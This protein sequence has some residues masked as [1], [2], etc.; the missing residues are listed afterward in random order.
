M[1]ISASY[2]TDI[3]AFYGPW[4]HNRLKA[5]FCHTTNPYNGKTLTVDLSPAAVSGYVFW[6][7]HL[8]PFFPALLDVQQQH[9]P[10]VV[11]MTITGYPRAIE[12]A[13]TPP[14]RAIAD[15]V[16]L[17]EQFGPGVGVWRY[18]PILITPL[19]PWAFH[20]KNFRTLSRE[21]TGVVDEVV[22]SF[23]HF[24]QKTQRNLARRET[25]QGL[26]LDWTDPPDE[27]K[28]AMLGEL[29]DMAAQA[30]LA[31][32]LCAQRQW[33]VEGVNDAACI[34][35]ARLTRLAGEPVPA[36]NKGHRPQCGCWAS[37]DIGDY[38][39]CPHGCVYCYAV[40]SRPLALKRFHQHDPASPF[41]FTPAVTLVAAHHQKA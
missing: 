16:S 34:D 12:T 25:P 37:R 28:K 27:T 9:K 31:L 1:I 20:L 23:T 41:L 36:G 10:F 8:R 15:L 33:L 4:F 19:T 39:T 22:V 38:D 26:G 29:R 40:R 14:R 30:G 32:S 17:R 11:Q 3:P 21:L 7:R 18:D 13:V 6:T 24:Y 2:R 35:A 5:G